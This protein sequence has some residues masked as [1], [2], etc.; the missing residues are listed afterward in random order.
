MVEAIYSYNEWGDVVL[1]ESEDV[2]VG[3]RECV[4]YTRMYEMVNLVAD[5]AYCEYC[6]I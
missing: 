1:E 6:A 4:G 5:V 2:I 3:C